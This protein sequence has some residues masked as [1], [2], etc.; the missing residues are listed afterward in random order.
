M[1][2]VVFESITNCQESFTIILCDFEQMKHKG[3][4]KFPLCN[5]LIMHSD[6]S[7]YFG[8]IVNNNNH[9]TF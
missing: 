6:E 5:V 2:S 3:F 9:N 4:K 8:A 7:V 1:N